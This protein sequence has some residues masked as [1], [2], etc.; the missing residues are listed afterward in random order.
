MLEALI[1]AQISL[2]RPEHGQHA[3]IVAE[4]AA[5][6]NHLCSTLRRIARREIETLDQIC[7]PPTRKRRT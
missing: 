7:Q 5:A 2:V 1:N 3:A 4:R 6:A